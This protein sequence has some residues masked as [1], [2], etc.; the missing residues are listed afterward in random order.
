MWQWFGRIKKPEEYKKKAAEQ[1][2]KV[3]DTGK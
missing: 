3:A 2:R 1:K